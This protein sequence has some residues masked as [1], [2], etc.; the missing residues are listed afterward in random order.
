MI[1]TTASKIG[2]HI[3]TRSKI[4]LLGRLLFSTDER[5]LDVLMA[6]PVITKRFGGYDKVED[7]MVDC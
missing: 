3:V 5:W 7:E 2:H 4:I 1:E 6:I